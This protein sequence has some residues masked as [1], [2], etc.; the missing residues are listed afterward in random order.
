MADIQGGSRE[1][2]LRAQL[3]RTDSL[4][5]RL[6]LLKALVTVAPGTAR[7]HYEYAREL[8]RTGGNDAEAIQEFREAL[9]L[10]PQHARAQL[11]LGIVYHRRGELELAEPLYTAALRANPRLTRAWLN[12][13]ALATSR[14][15]YRSAR[16]AYSRA[17]RQRPRDLA[18]RQGLARSLHALGKVGEA[19]PEWEE[20][21]ALGPTDPATL[22]GLARALR[23]TEDARAGEWYERAIAANPQSV[24]LRI[25]FARLLRG[26]GD[27]TRAEEVLREAVT[28][29]PGAARLWEELAGLLGEHGRE[30]DRLEVLR[31]GL[32]RTAGDEGL[33]MAFVRALCEREALAEAARE[34]RPLILAN[35]RNGPIRRLM[36]AIHAC[37][38]RYEEAASAAH[39]AL[40]IDRSEPSPRLLLMPVPNRPERPLSV[41]LHEDQQTP[42]AHRAYALAVRGVLRLA[43]GDTNE[44]ARLFDQAVK[45]SPETA[46]PRVGRAVVYL[47]SGSLEP[48]YAEL[49]T[50]AI[51]AP[52]E[53]HVQHLFGEAAFHRGL[54]EEA[55]EAF[56]AALADESV[57]NHL[58]A[59]TFFC[60]ARAFRKRGLTREAIDSYLQAERL[61][62]EYGASFFGCGKALQEVGRLEE[63][64]R[65]YERCVALSPKHAKA[66]Q[67]LA[68]CLA[69]LG[70]APQA[71]EAYRAAIAADQHYALPRYNLAALLDRAG[72][73]AE[74]AAL[75]RAYLK[76]E[77]NGPVA[78]D[79]RK[80]LRV[81]ELRLAG[82]L[83]SGPPLAEPEPSAP[84]LDSSQDDALY[85]G[86]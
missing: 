72:D 54:Y 24:S 50:A 48:A 32:V 80:R 10:D 77:P 15:D 44:A 1:Q 39:A 43:L 63:A 40:L 60:R 57:D 58:R 65:H 30:A 7:T 25:E 16:R 73:P 2:E 59:H 21:L 45:A 36:A 78:D 67:G 81:A 41:P 76:R 46:L 82:A 53:P 28:A 42:A 79:A 12:L 6:R 75:L 49:R 3:Q 74:V 23:A 13:G 20:A 5:E 11:G 61:D 19:V 69:S 51:L 56:Q 47:G 27:A 86:G 34:L 62:P 52:R 83:P 26:A 85:V 17:V 33:R 35:P 37:E 14:R 4:D 70:R 71:V 38:G 18:A 31:D 9:A 84:F 22:K 64:V 68:G 66:L 29:I 55:G 8:S